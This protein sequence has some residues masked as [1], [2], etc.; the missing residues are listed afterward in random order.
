MRKRLNLI[1]FAFSILFFTLFVG[2]HQSFAQCNLKIESKVEKTEP[3]QNSDIYL[4]LDRGSGSIN[5]YL[6]D[7]NKPQDGPVQRVQRS[8][9]E[10][11]NDFVVVFTD[12]PPSKYTIQAIDNNKC[13]VSIGGVEGITITSN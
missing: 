6:V 5:F 2:V 7:L 13:Q 12:V 9:S 10:L 11:R 1:G 8:A 3:S 4:K